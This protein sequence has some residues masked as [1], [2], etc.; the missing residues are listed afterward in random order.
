MALLKKNIAFNRWNE[1]LNIPDNSEQD[2]LIEK[3]GMKRFQ[4]KMF[5]DIRA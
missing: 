3:R 4:E 1:F 5:Q 2:L